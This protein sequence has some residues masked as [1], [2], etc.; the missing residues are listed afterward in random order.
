MRPLEIAL[1]VAVALSTARVLAGRSVPWSLTGAAGLTVVCIVLLVAQWAVEGGRWQMLPI[2]AAA[3]LLPA[4][5][6]AASAGPPVW[7]RLLLAA[8]ALGL[9]GAGASA[10][11][12]L[13]VFRLPPPTGPMLVGATDVQVPGPAGGFTTRVWYP[14]QRGTGQGAAPYEQASRSVLGRYRRQVITHSDRDA[15]FAAEAGRAPVIVYFAGWGGR[16]TE[17]TALL[18]D[19]ASHGFVVAAM[20]DMAHVGGMDFSS[21][22][23]SADTLARGGRKAVAEAQMAQALL[24]RLGALDAADPAGRF[25]HRL[26]LVHVGLLGYSFGGSAAATLALDDPRV[27]AVVNMDG[28]MFGPAAA[29]GVSQPYLLFSDDE[30]DPT[31]AQLDS[32]DPAT[33]YSSRFN[34]ADIM[35]NTGNMKRHGGWVATV[36]G[37]THTNFNDT[38]FRS[39]LRRLTGGGPIDPWRMQAVLR[40]YVRGFFTQVLLGTPS[41]LLQANSPAFP[42]VRLQAYRPAATAAL[43]GP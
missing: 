29:R 36:A 21:A 28:W 17:N 27:A 32:P 37:S 1:A 41:T 22:G 15:A 16:R 8:M 10:S 30:P 43:A 25:T 11:I 40:A 6:L 19:L 3:V 13:P 4:A 12:L 5:M 7:V 23:A 39:P 26:A 2:Y 24:G 14:A 38:G 31:R 42:E 18:E 35:A 33:R 9:L 34:L 20:D